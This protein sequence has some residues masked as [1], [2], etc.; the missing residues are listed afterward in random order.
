[1]LKHFLLGVALVLGL[2]VGASGAEVSKTPVVHMPR[3]AF[4]NAVWDYNR[5]KMGKGDESV[6]GSIQGL[7]GAQDS[8]MTYK[9]DGKFDA[10]EAR[11][12]YIT[13]T[14]EGR[15]AV[16]E[17]WADGSC[18]YTSDTIRSGESPE[19]VRVPVSKMQLLQLRIRPDRYE[20]THGAA[21]GEPYLYTGVGPDFLNTMVINNNGKIQRLTTGSRLN[22]VDVTVPLKPGNHEYT[23]KVQYDEKANRVDIETVPI[24]SAP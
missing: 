23:V 19:L 10:F 22:K 14:P 17:V 15:A 24:E 16:F 13:G 21:W 18:L 12:G 1:M 9:L 20:G 11:V 4:E 5:V 2:G 6:A 8:V 7:G 3:E